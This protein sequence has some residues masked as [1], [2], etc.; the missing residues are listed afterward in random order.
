MFYHHHHHHHFICSKAV[1]YANQVQQFNKNNEQDTPGCI[2]LM[3][4]LVI[5]LEASK[6]S[7]TNY[8]KVISTATH[9]STKVK[10]HKTA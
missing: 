8:N 3:V 2:A 10:T 5:K 1:Q 9:K 7:E 4:A 6:Y